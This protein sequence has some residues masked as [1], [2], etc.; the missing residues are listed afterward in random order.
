[1]NVSYISNTQTKQYFDSKKSKQSITFKGDSKIYA[2]S[3]LSVLYH[4]KIISFFNNFVEVKWKKSSQSK[5][6]YS[7]LKKHK[8]FLLIFQK[9]KRQNKF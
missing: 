3:T 2:C 9:D 8:F 6:F 5:S 7:K 4:S 1:M